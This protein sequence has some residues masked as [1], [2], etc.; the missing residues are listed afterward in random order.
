MCGLRLDAIAAELTTQKPSAKMAELVKRQRRMQMLGVF[1]LSA[2]GMIGLALL[3][4]E[5]V[6]YKLLILGSELLFGS[7]MG[8][9]ILFLLASVIF[10]N[11][12]KFFMKPGRPDP[13]LPG[14]TISTN[15]LLNDPPFEPASVTEHSTELL[16]RK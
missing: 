9:V 8:A 3:L 12:P 7:A 1:S 14:Q 16:L 11:Y 15:K 5:V 10:F 4:A 2:A 13:H 6:Y